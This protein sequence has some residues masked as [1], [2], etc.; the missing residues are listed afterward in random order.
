MAYNPAVRMPVSGQAPVIDPVTGRSGIPKPGHRTADPRR[1]IG[2]G[3]GGLATNPRTGLPNTPKGPYAGSINGGAVA[4]APAVR[5]GFQ[6]DPDTGQFLAGDPWAYAQS[7]AGERPE[8]GQYQDPQSLAERS[9][10]QNN[11]GAALANYDL[12]QNNVQNSFNELLNL[13]NKSKTRNLGSLADSMADRGL[14]NS[15]I[16]LN[17][18]ADVQNT[19]NDQLAG[20]TRQRDQQFNSIQQG[21]VNVA[22]ILAQAMAQADTDAY[23]RKLTAW[24]QM[25]DQGLK[26]AQAKVAAAQQAGMI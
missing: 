2:W 15:G 7:V 17:S 1:D 4:G 16:F 6:M 11:Y 20:N 14:S 19:F 24:Q 5:G 22:N 23:N 18:T 9:T 13:L 21:R 12:E 3:P 8:L 25:Y 10:A 26:E